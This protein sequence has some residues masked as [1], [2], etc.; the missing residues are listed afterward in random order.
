MWGS[1]PWLWQE[2]LRCVLKCYQGIHSQKRGTNKCLPRLDVRKRYTDITAPGKLWNWASCSAFEEHFFQRSNT[3]KVNTYLSGC[4]KSPTTK[5]YRFAHE[6]SKKEQVLLKN[7]F[8]HT[9]QC[10]K[11]NHSLTNSDWVKRVKLDFWQIEVEKILLFFCSITFLL[12]CFSIVFEKNIKFQ[13]RQQS[14]RIPRM[15]IMWWRK[16]EK[17]NC[18][19]PPRE[20]QIQR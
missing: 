8:L 3:T 14:G 19:A 16:D 4:S 15:V 7:S 10:Y 20:I 9:L 12:I 18:D 17:W 11:V 5:I 1:A 13:S 2:Y 6:V